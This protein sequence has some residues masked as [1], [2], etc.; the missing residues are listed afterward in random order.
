MLMFLVI[1]LHICG[2]SLRVAEDVLKEHNEESKIFFL[3]RLNKP[4][5]SLQVQHQH[6]CIKSRKWPE[7]GSCWAQATCGANGEVQI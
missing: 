7:Q 4:C 5:F 6:K 2:I 3:F 1:G